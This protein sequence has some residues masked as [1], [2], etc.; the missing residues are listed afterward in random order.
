MGVCKKVRTAGWLKQKPAGEGRRYIVL[1]A[2]GKTGFVPNSSLVYASKSNVGDYHG[3][4]PAGNF[5]KWL[6]EQ[7]QPNLEEL[8][9]IVM[10]NAPYHSKLIEKIPT[11]S[12]NKTE[13][14]EF[15]KENL[16][17]LKKT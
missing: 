10:D 5:N 1:S 3:E 17:R 4:M 15:L 2:G 7:L 11:T 16:Y 12:W 9:I 6:Q 8:S 14:K 13:I